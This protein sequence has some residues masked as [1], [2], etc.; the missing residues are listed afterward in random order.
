MKTKEPED[1]WKHFKP[2]AIEVLKLIEE[3]FDSISGLFNRKYTAGN[4]LTE[5]LESTFV[6]IPKK[7]N[8]K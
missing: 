1:I 5:W 7:R 2:A 3:Q 4:I 8:A 6:T